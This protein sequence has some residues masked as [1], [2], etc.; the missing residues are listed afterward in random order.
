M[1]NRIVSLSASGRIGRQH[2]S[3]LIISLLIL[4]V[5]TVTAVVAMQR[6]TLQLKMV[7]SM[8]RSQAVFNSTFGYLSQAQRL[9]NN[10]DNILSTRLMLSQLINDT[11]LKVDMFAINQWNAPAVPQQ[12]DP[13]SG[14]LTLS[15]LTV[16]N[17]KFDLKK[18]PGGNKE[19]VY[20]F[21]YNANGTDKSG[22]ITSNQEL[23]LTYKAPS[24]Q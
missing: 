18:N 20:Y 9:M 5:I 16:F 23:G 14:L 24:L 6:S 17:S 2:G 7:S 4:T 22:N 10:P 12:V 3:A 8:Q 19:S 13:V 1:S 21:R 11:E 15:N